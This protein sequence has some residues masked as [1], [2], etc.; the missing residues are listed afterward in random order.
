MKIADPSGGNPP[1]ASCARIF[2][3]D[4]KPDGGISP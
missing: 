3:A 1:V 2:K 4:R